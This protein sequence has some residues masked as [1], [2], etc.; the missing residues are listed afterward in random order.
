MEAFYRD[1]FAKVPPHIANYIVWGVLVVFGLFVVYLVYLYFITELGITT[2]NLTQ[3]W[4]KSF[5]ARAIKRR[6]K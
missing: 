6:K 2:Y 4:H 1:L 5:I 3:L